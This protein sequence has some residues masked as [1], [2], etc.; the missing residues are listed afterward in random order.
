MFTNKKRCHSFVEY[1]TEHTKVTPCRFL[2]HLLQNKKI[3]YI[4]EAVDNPYRFVLHTIY[5][6]TRFYV[7]LPF[8]TKRYLIDSQNKTK[9]IASCCMYYKTSTEARHFDNC[10]IIF[11][12]Q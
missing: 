1:F 2:S 6:F 5:T 3:S 7:V 4:T 11:I 9:N 8:R 10:F 12:C